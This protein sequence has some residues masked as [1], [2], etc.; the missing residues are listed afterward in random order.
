[1]LDLQ[2]LLTGGAILLAFAAGKMGPRWRLNGRS[3]RVSRRPVPPPRL[4][5]AAEQAPVDAADQLRVVM[6]AAFERQKLLSRDEA[7][8][9]LQVERAVAQAGLRWR[10]MAQVSLGE[11]LKTADR[12]AYSTI[13]SKRVDILLISS[14]GDPIAAIEYQG[15]GHHLGTAAARDAVKREA[16]RRA[17]VA[18]VEIAPDYSPE[19]VTREIERLAKSAAAAV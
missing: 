5:R 18:F 7:R 17:G 3:G 9:F 6:Q 8:V 4:V 16:L 12:R 14:S 13:N 10:T 15:S 19:D 1:M 11:V 2:I